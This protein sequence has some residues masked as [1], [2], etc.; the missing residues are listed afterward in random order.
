MTS[1]TIG[2]LK[3]REAPKWGGLKVERL[4]DSE[5]ER[6]RGF[7]TGRLEGWLLKFQNTQNTIP[8][9]PRI[10]WIK[11]KAKS[12]RDNENEIFQNLQF[13]ELKFRNLISNT[14]TA[15]YCIML[16]I[17]NTFNIS[18][19]NLLYWNIKVIIINTR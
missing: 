13:C 17:R 10:V 1:F 4:Q 9:F 14:S 16:T 18:L 5:V 7:E 8:G 12:I 3:G 11:S 15:S 2:K 6:L 19:C